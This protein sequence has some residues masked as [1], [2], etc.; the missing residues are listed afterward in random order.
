M[1]KLILFLVI[2]IAILDYGC[3]NDDDYVM[4]GQLYGSGYK[5]SQKMKGKVQEYTLSTFWAKEE[6]GK[7]VIGN[8]NPLEDKKSQQIT[9]PGRSR[10]QFNSSGTIIKREFFNASGE[11]KSYIIIEA[12][13]KIINK[14]MYYR[15][16]TLWAYSKNTYTGNN[17]TEVK[18][19]D[20][21][22]DTL[23]GRFVINYDQE[24]NRTK[25][26]VFNYKNEP[27][28]SNEFS[29]TYRS[30]GFT[31]HIKDY[32]VTGEMT[33][34]DQY[35]FNKQGDRIGEHW[36]RKIVNGVIGEKRDLIIKSENDKK[37]N[38]VR[39][40]FYIENQPYTLWEREI[41]Y[42]D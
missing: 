37:G 27:W 2:A 33:L 6:N 21:K 5:W 18:Y 8:G 23:Y 30:D 17:L 29:Y 40:V 35:V 36:D 39:R 13:G 9:G 25:V 38:W 4:D 11:I 34:H 1:K 7:V 31:Y 16:D 20:S 42:Y 32:S 26:Q 19:F 3:R 41:K 22:T 15:G 10:D 24:G 12:E 14:E 28:L